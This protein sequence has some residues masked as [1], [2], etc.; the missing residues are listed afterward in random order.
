MPASRYQRI[1]FG[2]TVLLGTSLSAA[3]R[4][5]GP[6]TYAFDTDARLTGPLTAQVLEKREGWIALPEDQPHHAFS[7]DAVFVNDRI[8]IAV[9]PGAEGIELYARSDEGPALRA[10]LGPTG[11]GS[12]PTAVKSTRLDECDRS[13][14][15]FAATFT[16]KGDPSLVLHAALQ[17]GQAVLATK[18]GG[19]VARLRVRAPCRFLVLPD[20]FADDMVIDAERLPVTAA[21]I[22]GE[23]FFLHL[24]GRGDAIV[25]PVWQK[26]GDDVRVALEERS[27]VR[28][29]VHSEIPYTDGGTIW[30]A[31]LDGSGMWHRHTVTPGDAG[32]KLR[33]DWTRPFPASWRVDWHTR[34]GEIDSWEMMVQK[35]DGTF[36]KLDWF[37]QAEDTGTLDWQDR[38]RKRWTTEF[39]RFLYPCWIDRQGR[40]WL[41]PLA[42]GASYAGP[43][44]IYP[45][46]RVRA[47]P[48]DAF[49]LVD[50]VRSTLG[51]GPCQYILDVEGQKKRTAGIP[52]CDARS[53]LN[54]IYKRGEQIARQDEVEQALRDA[55][56]FIRH[57]R[58]RIEEYVT[59]SHD[60][61]AYLEE[62]RTQHPAFSEFLE[63]M[64]AI[65][66]RTDACVERRKK[67]I[68]TP[69]FATKLIEGFR[70]DLVGYTGA[71]AH[72]RCVRF[73]KT[74]TVI[75]GAQDD[76]VAECRKVVRTLRQRA[77]LAM[78]LDPRLA[79]LAREIRRRTRQVL[80]S[81]VSYEAPR[82]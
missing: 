19:R 72:E 42:K 50:I 73:G 8:A 17:M 2:L 54:G 79:P 40:G 58:G 1:A 75:G 34:S 12:V 23:N 5:E 81:P 43:V 25:M 55:L 36:V 77:G 65:A 15:A 4:L 31:L 64:A 45:I 20:F 48:L 14:I 68:R 82:R 49:T 32:R 26:Q 44:L 57:I 59:F 38:G 10:V 35:P 7:G 76:L 3:D 9:R 60:M 56:A 46:D 37:G 6:F 29:I 78:A 62:Q 51:V 21:E 80:R 22:P 39:G 71:D 27:G 70:S 69:A 11:K 41:Q 67:A 53:I 33:L 66:R 52:T 16:G 24:A 47:T 18:P 13:R 61:I 63:E 30:L 28:R 74:L